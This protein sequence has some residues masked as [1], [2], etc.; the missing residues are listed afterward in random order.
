MRTLII[1]GKW[2]ADSPWHKVAVQLLKLLILLESCD[3]LLSGDW[4]RGYNTGP[5]LGPVFIAGLQAGIVREIQQNHMGEGESSPEKTMTCLVQSE[6]QS[7][8]LKYLIWTTRLCLTWPLY[9]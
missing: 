9:F 6:M 1:G 4:M 2:N 8:L 5:D 7:L 3:R